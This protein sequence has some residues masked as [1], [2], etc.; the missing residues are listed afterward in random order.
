MAQKYNKM[1]EKYNKEHPAL[2]VTSKQLRSYWHNCAK[3]GC[4][5][6]RRV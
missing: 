4:N 5:N 6:K 3:E 1:A 2:S